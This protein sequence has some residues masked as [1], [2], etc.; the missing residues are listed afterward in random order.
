MTEES[1]FER[2]MEQGARRKARRCRR[3]SSCSRRRARSWGA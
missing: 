2:D 3:R 1:N